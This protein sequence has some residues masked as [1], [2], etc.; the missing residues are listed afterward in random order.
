MNL[1]YLH[2]IIVNSQSIDKAQRQEGKLKA[3]LI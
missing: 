3:K 1:D 2:Q